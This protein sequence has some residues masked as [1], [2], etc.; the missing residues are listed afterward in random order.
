MHAREQST[1]IDARAERETAR[2]YAML[3]HLVVYVSPRFIR[4]QSWKHLNV[5]LNE[6]SGVFVLQAR[7]AKLQTPCLH[8]LE[9][10]AR[11]LFCAGPFSYLISQTVTPTAGKLQHKVTFICC[12]EI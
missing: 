10:F 1:R 7:I 8:N 3:V 12:D 2:F 11:I 9:G 5:R 6:Q 4:I